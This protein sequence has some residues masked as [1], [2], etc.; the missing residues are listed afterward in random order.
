MAKTMKPKVAPPPAPP[1]SIPEL[2]Q[3]TAEA[4]LALMRVTRLL[5]E[6]E[7]HELS[8]KRREGSR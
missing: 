4:S 8:E 3:A 2:R 1:P 7:R 5:A 6:A